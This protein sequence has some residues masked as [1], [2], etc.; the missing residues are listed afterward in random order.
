METPRVS[1]R[2]FLTRAALTWRSVLGDGGGQGPRTALLDARLPEP[3]AG[4]SGLA[5]NRRGGPGPCHGPCLGAL[6]PTARGD[7][8]VLWRLNILHLDHEASAQRGQEAASEGTPT[9]RAMVGGPK[10]RRPGRWM[11]TGTQRGARSQEERRL[12]TG[13]PHATASTER[14]Q[15]P[16]AE[17]RGL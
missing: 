12:T 3:Q 7:P 5:V 4:T 6:R 17:T 2:G 11:K 16:G 1:H 15:L 9:C 14:P 13:A 8:C 10:V